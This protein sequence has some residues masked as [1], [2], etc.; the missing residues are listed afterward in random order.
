M[1]EIPDTVGR[2]A[3]VVF[4]IHMQISI[5][6]WPMMSSRNAVSC[7]ENYAPASDARARDEQFYVIKLKHVN[8]F[9]S[10]LQLFCVEL[11]SK[12]CFLY[13]IQSVG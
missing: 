8:I 12:P 5:G 3:S 7:L 4:N 13:L 11:Y 2:D 9:L 10:Q 6:V 1:V